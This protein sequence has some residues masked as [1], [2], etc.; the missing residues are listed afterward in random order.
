M[1]RA[2]VS[3]AARRVASLA[4]GRTIPAARAFARPVMALSLP[5]IRTAFFPRSCSQGEGNGKDEEEKKGQEGLRRSRRSPRF[6]S[7]VGQQGSRTFGALAFGVGMVATTTTLTAGQAW[8]ADDKAKKHD[9]LPDNLTIIF[10]LGT[11][12]LLSPSQSICANT[13]F[14]CRRPGC[15]QGNAVRAAGERVQLCASQRR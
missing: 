7:L 11:V 8:A 10:V 15:W 12:Q 4:T 3:S 1:F 6:P 9:K 2:I 14:S 13:S 5:A